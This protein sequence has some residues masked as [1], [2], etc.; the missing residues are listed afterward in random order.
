MTLEELRAQIDTVDAELLQLFLQRLAVSEQIGDYKKEN[1]LPVLDAQRQERKL[2]EL[3]KLT[4]ER[5]REA[6]CRLFSELMAISRA[7]QEGTV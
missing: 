2:D 5:D 6:V 4:P 7:R 1:G 3:C